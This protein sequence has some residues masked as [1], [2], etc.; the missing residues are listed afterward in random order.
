MKWTPGAQSDDIEDVRGMSTGGRGFGG[1]GFAM[2]LTGSGIVIAIILAIASQ[3]CGVNFLGG[4][5]DDQQTQPTQQQPTQYSQSPQESQPR[6]ANDP[7]KHTM[8]FVSFVLDDVQKTFDQMFAE[9]G[10]KYRH[11]HLVVFTDDIDTG[12]GESS[13]AVGPFYCPPDEKAYI[14]LSFFQELHDRF[15]A[16]GEFAQ[17]YV[18]AHELGHHVQHLLGI[19]EKIGRGHDDSIRL[20]LQADCFAGVWGHS[21]DQRHLLDEGEAREAIDAAA[22]IGDDR[23]QKMSGRRVNPETWTHGSSDQRVKWFRRGFESGRFED[24]DTFTARDL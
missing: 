24:C 10:W 18:L 7:E 3:V 13:A 23:L 15:G 22:S 9:H 12:C 14:D 11:A 6:G 21:T 20:E 16:A 1:R 8:Q 19:D 17:A 4:G 5:G 2:P